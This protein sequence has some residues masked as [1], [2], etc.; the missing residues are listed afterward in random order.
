MKLVTLFFAA[1]ALFG[2]VATTQ[3]EEPK[4]PVVVAYQELIA[5]DLRL[6]TVGYHLAKGS[7]DYCRNKWRNP[8][9]VLHDERQYPDLGLAHRVF[10]FRQ[11][12]SIAAVVAGGPAHRA[13][14]I[15]GDGLFG[16]DGSV[17]WYGPSPKRH[18]PSSERIDG[19]RDEFATRLSEGR[20]IPF[21]I[22][23]AKGRRD[24]LLDSP[25]ICASDF[26]V[27]ARAKRDAGADGV[28]VR[29]TS[30]LIDYVLDDDELAAVV[31]H[32]MA[33]NLLD[34]RSLIEAAKSG[35]TKVI[36]A[37]EAEADRL[38]VWLMSNA[39]YDAE[40]AISFWQR[41]GKATGLGIFSAPTHYRWPDRVTM[42][43]QEI[44]QI[45]TLSKSNVPQD[46]P[47]L[48]AHRAQ[49]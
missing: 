29:V 3:D 1:I 12:I 41:Y 37:T 13:G 42:L 23:T 31:A 27:D 49:K 36:K 10:T 33:H 5:K 45:R 8:G 2:A 32:E 11:P 19:L 20:P 9:W 17:V 48:A 7:A 28:R 6:A 25:A 14:L 26:W 4:D 15:A 35:K 34:H 39:G 38:S 16:A 30:G 46:P 18:Q 24:F 21:Q 22:D 43:R 47:L 40:A 44:D